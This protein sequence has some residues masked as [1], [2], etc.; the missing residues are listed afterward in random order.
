MRN[1]FTP[2]DL[3]AA[4][5]NRSKHGKFIQN[6][7]GRRLFRHLLDSFQN[8]LPVAHNVKTMLR[9]I[10]QRKPYLNRDRGF[11]AGMRVVVHQFE[12]FKFEI[13]DVFYGGIYF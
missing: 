3:F 1:A 9:K 10:Y 12:I 8:K 2:F 13:V 7:F 6:L 11:D 4:A 5:L